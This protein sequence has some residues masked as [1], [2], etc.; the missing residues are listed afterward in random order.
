[1][2]SKFL[3]N[4]AEVNGTIIAPYSSTCDVA[5]QSQTVPYIRRSMEYEGYDSKIFSSLSPATITA[6]IML[7]F[8]TTRSF[9]SG[10]MS[11]L[12]TN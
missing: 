5:Y 8:A 12:T 2:T 6:S 4:P 3:A 1:M 7:K 9:G 11:I 10:T